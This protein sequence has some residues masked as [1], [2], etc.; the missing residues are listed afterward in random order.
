MDIFKYDYYQG[1]NIGVYTLVND[2]FIF[3]PSGFAKTKAEKIS[4]YLQVRQVFTS[5]AGTRL[6]GA[7]CVANNRGMLVP[8]MVSEG[9]L[10][11]FSG[12]GLDVQILDSKFTA[13]GNLICA[14]DHGAV[15]SPMISGAGV[16]QI[17]DVLGVEVLQKKVAGYYQ[18]GTMI[19]ATNS[20]GVIHP[21]TRQADIDAVSSVLKVKVEPATING[22]VPF[23]SSGILA[24]NKSIVVGS[25]TSG[26]EIMML[27]RAFIQ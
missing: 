18:V 26:P 21:E 9:E 10:E 6:L 14:N 23:V 11:A 17:R 22:G 1:P 19:V 25:L 16:R 5:V 27:T 24:N 13:L 7:L 8:P 3:L 2:E 15:V 20:G 12:T 4:E